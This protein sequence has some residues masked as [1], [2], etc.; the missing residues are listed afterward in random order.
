LLEKLQRHLQL[1]WVYESIDS[2]SVETVRQSGNIDSTA[3]ISITVPSDEE[4]KNLYRLALIG[5]VIGLQ[6]QADILEQHS[7]EWM[8]FATELRQL[9][10]SF[11]VK[12]LQEFIRQYMNSNE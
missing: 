6:K 2:P 7:E 1:E 3:K 10:K 8:S 4:I 12:K 11:Q 9:A 5:D